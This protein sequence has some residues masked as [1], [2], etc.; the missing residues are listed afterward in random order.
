[1]LQFRFGRAVFTCS[2]RNGGVSTGEYSTANIGDHVGDDPHAVAQNRERLA[3]ACGVDTIVFAQQVHGND[4][5]TIEGASHRTPPLETALVADA[6]VLSHSG[7]GVA[8]MT[9]DCMPIGIATQGGSHLAVIHAGWRG[10]LAGVIEST[11]ETLRALPDAGTPEQWDAIIGPCARAATYEFGEPDLGVLA[12]HFGEEIRSTTRQGTPSAD[13]VYGAREVIE[14][15]G[16]RRAIDCEINT[17]DD[18]DYFSYRRSG[19]TGRQALIGVLDAV[20]PVTRN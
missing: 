6:F 1:M 4:V 13:L 15:L 8:M 18:P 20:E 9:A 19:V 14:R 16:I 12:A 10:L 2:N 3:I 11:V 17:M 7:V 5:H